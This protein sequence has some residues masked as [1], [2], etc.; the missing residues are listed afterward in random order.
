MK[1]IFYIFLIFFSKSVPSADAYSD[2]EVI[3]S[4]KIFF[5]QFLIDEK[6]TLPSKDLNVL[7]YS[8]K[9]RLSQV[10]KKLEILSEIGISSRNLNSTYNITN[11]FLKTPSSGITKNLNLDPRWLEVNQKYNPILSKNDR[12]VIHNSHKNNNFYLFK[13][14]ELC[15]V[16]INN[17]LNI[18]DYLDIC[19]LKVASFLWIIDSKGNYK[20]FGVS[21]WNNNENIPISTGSLVITDSFEFK[22]KSLFEKIIKWISHNF[23]YLNIN[24]SIINKSIISKQDSSREDLIKTN[25]NVNPSSWGITGLID[26]P[27]ARFRPEGT[28]LLQINETHPIRRYNFIFSPFDWFE[29]GF[30]YVSIQNRY[31]SEDIAFSGTQSYKDKNFEFKLRL[32]KETNYLPQFAIGLRDF[33]GTGLFSSEYLTSS[34]RLGNFDFTLGSGFGYLSSADHNFDNPLSFLKSEF[35]KRPG[36][37][38][39]LGG[40]FNNKTWFRGRGSFFGGANYSFNDNLSLKIDYSSNQYNQQY[41]NKQSILNYGI[42]YDSND[43]M[44]LHAGYGS[45]NDINFGVSIKSDLTNQVYKKKRIQQSK[46]NNESSGWINNVVSKV[47]SSINWEISS[48]I[49]RKNTLIFVISNKIKQNSFETKLAL[50]SEIINLEIP[51]KYS[52]FEINFLNLEIENKFFVIDRK[53]FALKR[54]LYVNDETD[55]NNFYKEKQQEDL[56]GNEIYKNKDFYSFK[57]NPSYKQTLGGPDGFVLYS[58][59]AKLKAEAKFNED[60]KIIV[61]ARKGLIDNYNKYKQIGRSNVPQVRTYLRQYATQS[62]MTLPSLQLL[63]LKKYNSLKYM[64]YVGAPEEMFAGYGGEFFHPI[65][66][67]LYISYDYNFVRQREFRQLFSLRDYSAETSHINL[68]YL[69]PISDLV[70]NYAYGKYLAGDKGYTINLFR[71]FNNGSKMGAF[72]TRTDLSFEDFGEGSFDKGIYFEIPFDNILPIYSNNYAKIQWKP[73]SRDGGAMLKKRRIFNEIY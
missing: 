15:K 22:N 33:A 12:V 3:I 60:S 72:F 71:K 17:K 31:Y 59:G 2:R 28:L 62:G 53:K 14:N 39:V 29:G 11:F 70:L 16:R 1:L 49:D 44:Y 46:T 52:S 63:T 23:D 4:K 34:K 54:Y 68:Y 41:F 73:L 36:V 56:I 38:S 67:N 37:D 47:K 35:K 45:S 32:F 6:L 61:E 50:T 25:N 5:H 42:V 20:K 21:D 30:R 18:F 10:N 8:E 27:S 55:R 69:T 24:F 66:D 51:K 48:I 9:N 13:G 40:D 43:W 19:E 64:L 57:L 7:W 58:L 26:S 65:I